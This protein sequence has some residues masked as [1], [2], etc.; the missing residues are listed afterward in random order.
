MT[1]FYSIHAHDQ[2]S[3]YHAEQ[4]LIEN[5]TLYPSFDKACDAVDRYIRDMIDDYKQPDR[6]VLILRF[7][8]YRY[9]HYYEIDDSGILCVISK[10]CVKD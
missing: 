1:T 8:K 5:H 10:W 9:I 7:D 3:H 4:D 6:D 2:Q